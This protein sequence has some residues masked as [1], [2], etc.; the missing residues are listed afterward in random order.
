LGAL[1]SLLEDQASQDMLGNWLHHLEQTE[2]RKDKWPS[3]AREAVCGLC[4]QPDSEW[5]R[6]G[7]SLTS[8]GG[9]VTVP[10]LSEEQLKQEFLWD[11]IR[12]SWLAAMHS[13]LRD[14]EEE[15]RKGATEGN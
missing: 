12:A 6:S 7:V 14:R 2:D 1:R 5:S 15:Q 3:K 9:F 13:E 11:W 8:H 10:G 4:E